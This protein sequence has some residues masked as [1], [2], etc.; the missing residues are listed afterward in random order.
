MEVSPKDILER[1]ANG[2]AK[3]IEGELIPIATDLK[4]KSFLGDMEYNTIAKTPAIP[5]LERANTLVQHV[6]TQV[7]VAPEKFHHFT[8]VLKKHGKLSSVKRLIDPDGEFDT[9][10]KL[11]FDHCYSY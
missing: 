11:K 8:D 3:I 6:I 9:H 10:C 1:S 7:D 4:A 5:P 2:I